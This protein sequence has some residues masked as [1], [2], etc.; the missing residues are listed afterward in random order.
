MDNLKTQ[1]TA[2]A[3]LFNWNYLCTELEVSVTYFEC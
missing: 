3:R 1:G 2:E